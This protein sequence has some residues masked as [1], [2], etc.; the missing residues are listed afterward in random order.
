[1]SADTIVNAARLAW[2]IISSG[3]ASAEIGSSTAN[4]V[5]QVDDWQ[6]LTG[7]TGPNGYRMYT[8]RGFLWPFDD[9]DH[10][11]IEIKLRWEYGARYKGGGAYIPNV[12]VEVPQCFVGYPWDANISFQAMD[13]S[14]AGTEEAPL[15]RLPVLV[16]GTVSSGAELHHVEWSFVLF[17][18]GTSQQN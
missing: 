4:A 5:P 16:K 9:Y 17:G 10:V 14:N 2:E 13:P 8:S 6:S 18:D 12:W 11:Q 15:A 1:M 7:T 3:E